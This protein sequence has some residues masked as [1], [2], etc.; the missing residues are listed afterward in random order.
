MFAN[1]LWQVQRC[2]H[3][4]SDSL[5]RIAFPAALVSLGGV[6]VLY[7]HWQENS[8]VLQHWVGLEESAG[9]VVQMLPL[10]FLEK[11][12]LSCPDPVSMLSRFGSKAEPAWADTAE[13]CS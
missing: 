13:R 4:S 8:R 5:R 1:R 10:V 12:I 2:L 9:I 11:Q 6:L 7:K 3:G